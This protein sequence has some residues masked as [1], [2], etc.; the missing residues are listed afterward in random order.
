M[1]RNEN[2]PF[3][4]GTL[5]TGYSDPYTV[6]GTD[7]THLEGM[8][9]VFEDKDLANAVDGVV[10]DRTNQFVHCRVVRNVGTTTLTP[11]KF[12]AFQTNGNA[13]T[14]P[15]AYGG[16]VQGFGTIGQAGVIVDEFLPSTGAATNDL[17]WGVVQGPTRV[18][19]DT[20]GDTTISVGNF[21]VPGST[22]DGTVVDQDTNAT[23]GT[24]STA[25]YQ[26]ALGRAMTACSATATDFLINMRRMGA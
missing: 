19:S 17:F 3:P 15:Q 4:R 26:G 9:W 5:G 21:V 11:K 13:T 2:P 23:A 6:S 22:G 1:A 12:A 16:R 20:S 18:T 10:P 14:A 25:Q 24:N 8:E 7:L